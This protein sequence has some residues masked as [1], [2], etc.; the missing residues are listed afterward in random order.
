M[1]Q[2]FAP[3]SWGNVQEWCRKLADAIDLLANGTSRTVWSVTLTANATSTTVSSVYVTPS[4]HITLT[5]TTLNAA[6]E[7]G[8]GTAYIS[9]RNNGASFV[10]T[11]ANNAQTDR[12][13]SYEVRNP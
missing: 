4:S 1:A 13:F 3:K 2:I 5:P 6:A 12:T 9:A 8:N 11:H 10:I 7:L